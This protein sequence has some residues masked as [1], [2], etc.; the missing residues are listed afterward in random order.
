MA[1]AAAS[2]KQRGDTAHTA[3][4]A[5]VILALAAGFAFVPRVTQSCG[6]SSGTQEA[7]DFTASV[8]ANSL[9]PAQKTM[10]MSALRGHPVVLDFWA[11]WCGPCQAEAPIVNAVAQRFKDKGLI[12][13]GVN[14]SDTEGRTLAPI[15]ALRK[16]LTFPIVYDDGDAIA[17]KYN[18]DNL[19]TLV[20][21]SK[22]G[23]MVAVRHGVTSDADLE[24]L[25][26]QVL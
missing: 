24:R 7:P 2:P 25:V 1:D 19:P 4:M 11:T 15:F 10:T 21:V 16:G 12:V 9:D 5:L 20:I 22:E 18:V 6:K 26:R 13:I 14:T 17:H 3:R 23:K 8:I